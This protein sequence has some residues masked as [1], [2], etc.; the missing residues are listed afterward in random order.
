MSGKVAA[1]NR[2][3]VTLH[4]DRWSWSGKAPDGNTIVLQLWK[5]RLNYK[6]KPISY[7]DFKDPLLPQWRDRPGNKERI[8]NLRWALSHCNGK[9]RVVIGVAKDTKAQPRETLE[10]F[11]QPNMLMKITDFDEE[12]GEFSAEQ[13]AD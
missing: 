1:F 4:N 10:A 13:V 12:T 7:S 9:F 8:D 2:F 11:A 6:T 5:D 3:G